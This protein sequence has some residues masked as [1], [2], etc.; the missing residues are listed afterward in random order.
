MIMVDNKPLC[1]VSAH[2]HPALDFNLQGTPLLRK[3]EMFPKWVRMPKLSQGD[4]SEEG[5]EGC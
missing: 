2:S 1:L 3:K 5:A 4:A